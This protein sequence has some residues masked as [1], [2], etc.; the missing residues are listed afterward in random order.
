MNG[1][2]TRSMRAMTLEK[3]RDDARDAREAFGQER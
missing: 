3:N 2:Q 1:R